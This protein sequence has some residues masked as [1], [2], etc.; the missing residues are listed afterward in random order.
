V[1][2]IAFVSEPSCFTIAEANA[3]VPR[4]E[5]LMER[6]QRV[7]LVLRSALQDPADSTPARTTAEVLRVRPDLADQVRELESA[8][9]AIEE[10]GCL[11]KGLDLGLVDFPA[12]VDGTTVLLCWQYGEKQIA[13]WHRTDEGFA[14][15]RPL[16]TAAIPVLQ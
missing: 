6:A 8:V 16:A 2:R 5:M 7:A 11:F 12:R 4:L 1:F 13:Y 3:L 9:G 15:R 10:L 14:N